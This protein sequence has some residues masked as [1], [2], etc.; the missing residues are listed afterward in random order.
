MDDF[1]EGLGFLENARDAVHKRDDLRKFIDQKKDL[2]KKME[3]D[4][5]AEEKDIADEINS[6]IKKKRN[7]IEDSFDKKLDDRKSDVKKLEKNRKKDKSGQVNARVAEA[8]K[9]Y[10]AQN[11]TLEDELKDLFKSNGVPKFCSGKFYYTL[12][13]PKGFGEVMTKLLFLV[14]VALGVPAV[15]VLLLWKTTFAGVARE[16]KLLYSIIFAVVWIIFCIVI[17]FIIYINTK[18]RYIDTI[19]KGRRYR[20][21]I[22]KNTSSVNKITDSIN[23]DKDESQY[24]ISE[25]DKKLKDMDKN[26]DRLMSEKKDALKEFDK[27]TKDEITKDIKKKRQ[28][29][30]DEL[31]KQKDLINAELEKSSEELNAAE[32]GLGKYIRV[33][34][35][36]NCSAEMIEKLIGVIQSG[37]AY[38]A[39]EAIGYLKFK[40]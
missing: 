25:Y 5:A 24:N 1:T 29:K 13:N 11:K 16:K 6:T 8:T 9:D 23:K 31:A 20:D 14:T 26:M 21:A 17:Y 2:L 12:F 28:K 7:S 33:L 38:T 30:L 15:V 39:K 27:K 32:N 18:V 34:G 4:I 37:R 35:E 22:K 36:E 10:H 19:R 3:K 40:G